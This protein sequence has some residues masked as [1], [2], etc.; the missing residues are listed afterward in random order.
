MEELIEWRNDSSSETDDKVV[1][2]LAQA[3]AHR[4]KMSAL[5]ALVGVLVSSITTIATSTISELPPSAAVAS[6][7][8]SS[9]PSCIA[10]SFLALGG[11]GKKRSTLPEKK[12]NTIGSY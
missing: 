2:I 6:G 5:T 9:V 3:E 1:L 10:A 11:R 12:K 4:I 7:A 8:T